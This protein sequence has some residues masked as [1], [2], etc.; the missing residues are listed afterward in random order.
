MGNTTNTTTVD[1]MA[2]K[3]GQLSAAILLL[4]G[5]LLSNPWI[6]FFT[7][8]CQLLSALDVPFAPFKLSYRYLVKPSG[9][10]KPNL[11]EDHERPHR[12]AS[13]VGGLFDL[14]GAILIV[15]GVPVVG[16]ALVWIVIA[17]ANLNVWGNFCMGCWMFYRFNRLGV[18]GFALEH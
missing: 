12:F 1:Q 3:N 17:L 9:L 15:A 5:F 16:W 8:V 18:P 14:V 11:Q 6:I 4:I 13:L 10:I 2:V 7:A